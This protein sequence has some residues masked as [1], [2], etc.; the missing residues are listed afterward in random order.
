MLKPLNLFIALRYLRAK[1]RRNRFM[2][3][4]S[5]V[6]MLGIALGVTVLITVLSVMNGFDNAIKAKIFSVARQVTISTVDGR[7]QHWQTLAQRLQ[8]YP[9]IIASSPYLDTQAM[10]KS[11]YGDM[12]ASGIV[13]ILPAQENT[14]VD[15]KHK[16]LFGHITS[17]APKAFNIVLGVKLAASLGVGL[18]DKVTLMVPKAT[19]SPAGLIPQLRRFTVSGIFSMGDNMAY[20][21]QL[22]FINLSDAKALMQMPSAVTGLRLKLTDLYQAPR[23]AQQ[24]QQN[25]GDDFVVGDWTQQ[26][27]NFFSAIRLEKT[28]IFLLL[29]F[30]IAVAAFNLVSS[31]VMLVND[32][33]AD[34]AILRTLGASPKFI[35]SIFMLQGALVGLLGTGLGLLGGIVLSLNVTAVTNFIQRVFHVQ[36]ISANIYFVDY[37]PSKLMLSDII[38]VCVITLGFAFL[39]TLYPAWQASKTQPAEALRY[40]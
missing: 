37:L 18:H 9:Q 23:V 32:K 28:M 38:H 17:L 16:M 7:L 40:E 12:R 24:L 8:A 36:L 31:L 10:L 1:K 29:T 21:S 20:D 27:G 19:L 25:L 35:L 15:L 22:A 26:F 30:I 3:F 34:I 6:S 2:S 13:G 11:D 4:I 14:V 39:A 33:R 5:L